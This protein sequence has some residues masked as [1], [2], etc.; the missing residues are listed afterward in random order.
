M[1]E[2]ISNVRGTILLWRH[3]VVSWV[4]DTLKGRRDLVAEWWAACPTAIHD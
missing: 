2:M 4:S 1:S 3:E